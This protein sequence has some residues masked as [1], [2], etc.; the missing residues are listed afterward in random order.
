MVRFHTLL[1][2]LQKQEVMKNIKDSANDKKLVEGW[3]VIYRTLTKYGFQY[4]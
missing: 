1:I 2:E 3:I 4:K